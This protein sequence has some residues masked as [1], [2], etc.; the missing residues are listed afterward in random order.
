MKLKEIA[1]QFKLEY[2]GDADIDIR[3]IAGLRD[4]QSD[5]LSFLYNRKYRRTL[6]ES[7]AGA[8][9]LRAE[10]A[11]DDGRNYLIAKNP[12]LAWAR[13]AT[14]FDTAPL[15]M[16]FIDK[17]A[18]VSDLARLADRVAIGPHA[19]L[20]P[21]V[22]IADDVQV[23]AGCYLGEG[24]RI[25]CGT[26]IMPNTVIYH[27]VSIGENCLIHANVVIGA[28]GFGFEFDEDSGE[29]VKV[30][31]VCGVGVGDNVE[32]G[33]GST[34]DRGAL[35]DTRICDGCKLDNQVQ[36]GHGTVIE[37]HTVISG[38][39]AIGGSTRIGS[40]CLIGGAVGII[41]NIE[42]ANNVEISAMTLVSQ[43]IVDTGRYSSGTG[44]MR[45]SEW[46]R[47]IVG[48]KKLDEIMKRLRRLESAS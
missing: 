23:G 1:E 28:D 9:L 36:V 38:C 5:Q 45:G 21:G 20:R 3:G 19:V 12:R 10:D 29:Y 39:T 24:V 44:M 15:A 13:I 37:H 7:H 35:N 26:K 48:F 25:G 11:T 34:I 2:R 41:D 8:V 31:Q 22:A 16:P 46:K 6:P 14:L 27:D 30:P 43:S 4:A 32:I 47:S 18:W 33:A 40:Y 17:T 42:I